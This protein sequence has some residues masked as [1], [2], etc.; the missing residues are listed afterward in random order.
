MFAEKLNNWNFFVNFERNNQHIVF[1][2]DFKVELW[3]SKKIIYFI[4]KPFKNDENF[5]FLTSSFRCQDIEVF[6][7]TFWSCRKNGFIRKIKWTAKFMTS[8]PG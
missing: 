3:P 8:Q 2:V 6:I 4:E 5:F 1:I 7:M